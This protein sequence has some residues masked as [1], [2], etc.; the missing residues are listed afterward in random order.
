M[1]ATHAGEPI[2]KAPLSAGVQQAVADLRLRL[3]TGN[4]TLLGI[5]G[6]PG[7]GKSAFAACLSELLGADSTRVVPMDGFHLGNA[8]IDGTALRDR[9]G[10]IDTFDVGGYAS[11]L[12][13]LARADEAVV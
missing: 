8:M 3:A 10:A 13:R 1:Q 11:L 4:R 12:Q 7:S 2:T 5:V 6:A 9:K